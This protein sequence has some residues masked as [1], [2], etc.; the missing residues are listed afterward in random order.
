MDRHGG[1][2]TDK[3]DAIDFFHMQVD[4]PAGKVF[5]YNGLHLI[6]YKD[7]RGTYYK[8]NAW[9]YLWKAVRLGVEDCNIKDCDVCPPM[10]SSI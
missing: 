2:L 7:V 10:P 8:D 9:W 4:L 5:T 1:T 3:T 6:I